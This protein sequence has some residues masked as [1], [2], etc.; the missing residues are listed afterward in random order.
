MFGPNTHPEPGFADSADFSGRVDGFRCHATEWLRERRAWLVREQRRLHVDE[1]AVTRVLDER[2]AIDDTLAQADGVSVRSVRETVATA[3][4]LEDLPEIARVAAAGGLSDEQLTQVVKVADPADPSDDARWAAE[5]ASWS[6]ADLAHQAR[7]KAKPT[8]EEGLA[9]RA[10]RELG[11]WWRRDQG[12][13]DGRF[14][15]PDVDGALFE[16]VINHMVDR[17]KPAKGQPW[18]TRAR[19]GADALVELVRNY[20]DVGAVS[21]PAPHLVVE[22]PMEGPAL[23]AGVPLPDAMVESLRAQAKVEPVLVDHDGTTVAAG[24]TTGVVSPKKLR[25]VRLRDGKCRV[26]GCDR[27]TGLEAHHL[28]PSSWGG[29]DEIHNLAMVCTGGSTD[30]HARLVPH[31]PYLLLGNPN[32]PDGL[33]LVHRDDLTRSAQREGEYTAKR[34]AHDARAG[35]EAA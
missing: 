27:R 3:R 20:A 26:P 33:T 11:F 5:A 34:A 13:L 4:A 12:M 23:L 30:H 28:C 35:P 29:A 24:R 17:M 25:A 32:D 9:R 1:L 10:A 14:S 15:L 6:P 18:E 2:G 8:T 22:V 16:S 21:G 19:R 31:G 7:C